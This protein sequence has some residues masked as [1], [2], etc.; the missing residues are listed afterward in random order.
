MGGDK[1]KKEKEKHKHKDKHKDKHKEKHHKHDKEKSHKRSRSEPEP[2]DSKRHRSSEPAEAAEAVLRRLIDASPKG[3]K[4]VHTLLSMLDTGEA[5]L[6]AF[7]TAWAW[8]DHGPEPPRHTRRRAW[9]SW[10]RVLPHDTPRPCESAWGA[11]GPPVGLASGVHGRDS[12]HVLE[13]DAC[14]MQ[15]RRSCWSISR[16]RAW[17]ESSRASPSASASDSRRWTTAVWHT[18]APAQHGARVAPH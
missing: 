18:A 4:D 13:H 6:Q 8:G 16:T 10:P 9:W 2:S 12:A 14:T 15:R 1:H 11:V 5:L 3:A 17:R 7:R